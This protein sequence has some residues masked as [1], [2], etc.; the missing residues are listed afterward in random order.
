[1]TLHRDDTTSAATWTFHC[2]VCEHG[3]TSAGAGQAQAVA[4][5]TTNGWIV[6]NMTLCPGCAAARDHA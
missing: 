2:D 5:A 3:F 1:M 4:D 6:S